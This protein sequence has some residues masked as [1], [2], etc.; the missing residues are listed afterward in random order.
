MRMSSAGATVLLGVVV[1]IALTVGMTA[2]AFGG[3]KKGPYLIYGGANTQMDVLWQTETEEV[4]I[5]EWGLAPDDLTGSCVSVEYEDDHQHRETIVDLLPG[6]LYHYR[7]N[8]GGE[9]HRGTFLTAPPADAD[10]VKFLVYGDTRSDEDHLEDIEDH[11]EVCGSIVSAYTADPESQ[12]FLLHVGDF[13]YDGDE[14]SHWAGQYFAREIDGSPTN[15]LPMQANIPILGTMGNHERQGDLFRKYWP[16]PVVADRY[17]SFDYGPV[18]I[19]VVDQYVDYDE[20]S[21]QLTWLANDLASST[22]EW[23]FILL[24]EPGWSAGDPGNNNNEDVKNYIQPLC[25]AHGVDMLIAGHNHNYALAWVSGVWHVTSGGG[26]GPLDD[27]DPDHPNVLAAG[28]TFQFCKVHIRAEVL[29][30]DVIEPGGTLVHRFSNL[31]GPMDYVWV[32]LEWDGDEDGSWAKP[33]NTLEEGVVDVAD[34]GKIHIQP[35][36]SS[37]VLEISKGVTL[38][39]PNGSAV[40]G[41]PR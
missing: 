34:G 19:A 2:S 40:I 37:E 26:G 3:M 12:T 13:V 27:V 30:C 4:D 32:N 7:V 41:L 1:G 35:G 24:H 9:Y 28:K 31:E 29:V 17:W 20:G 10:E 21:A 8:A 16:Y 15:M 14:E 23:K 22:K 33:F 38:W 6:T 39:A 5:L 11:N 25:V 36:T 18:H